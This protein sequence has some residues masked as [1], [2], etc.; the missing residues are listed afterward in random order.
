MA[1]YEEDDATAV[2]STKAIKA[3]SIRA[4]PGNAG[5]AGWLFAALPTTT[6]DTVLAISLMSLFAGRGLVTF[7]GVQQIT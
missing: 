7:K 3:I 4:T 5:Q 2:V 6:I 1:A